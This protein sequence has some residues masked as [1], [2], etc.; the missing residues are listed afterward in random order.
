MEAADWRGRSLQKQLNLKAAR[1]EW[2]ETLEETLD[3]D[4]GGG[5]GGREKKEQSEYVRGSKGENKGA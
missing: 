5:A 1:E 4:K 3:R 2:G